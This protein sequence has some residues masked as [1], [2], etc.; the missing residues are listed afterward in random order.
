[1]RVSL[2]I[3]SAYAIKEFLCRDARG[4]TVGYANRQSF[5]RLSLPIGLVDNG[6][7]ETSELSV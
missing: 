1:M 5:Q 2:K 6:A 7:C 4:R 3:K